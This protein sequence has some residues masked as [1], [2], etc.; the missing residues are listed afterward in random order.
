MMVMQRMLLMFTAL[1]TATTFVVQV[2]E[3]DGKISALI[4]VIIAFFVLR[5]TF[6][7]RERK[8]SN[9]D[10]NDNYDDDHTCINHYDF[11][12]QRCFRL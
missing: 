2:S 8:S 12:R 7:N 5:H 6:P 1:E 9:D 11:L 3:S 10:C 4:I